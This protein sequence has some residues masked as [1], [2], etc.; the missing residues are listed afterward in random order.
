M[1]SPGNASWSK[2][3]RSLSICVTYENRA[4]S[5]LVNAGEAMKAPN[6]TTHR[7]KIMR[8]IRACIA[9]LIEVRVLAAELMLTA[10]A[11]Y[12]CY[13]AFQDLIHRLL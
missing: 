13:I 5:R 12:A 4:Y 11:L 1:V 10:A 8:F 3:T 7:S 2:F 9:I 6:S